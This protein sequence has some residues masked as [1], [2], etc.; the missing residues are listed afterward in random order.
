[1]RELAIL[2]RYQI[3]TYVTIRHTL[4]NKFTVKSTKHSKQTE[5]IKFL[6]LDLRKKIGETNMM[7]YLTSD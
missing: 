6:N 2:P 3:I 1:M 7:K 5:G 4:V